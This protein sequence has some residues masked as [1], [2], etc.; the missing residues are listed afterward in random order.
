VIADLSVNHVERVVLLEG[1][2][3]QRIIPDYGYD[4]SITTCDVDGYV[5]NGLIFLQLKASESLPS[6]GSDFVFDA[7]VR[8]Y[9]LW[10]NERFPVMLILDDAG[11][12]RAYWLHIQGYFL[13]PDRRPKR[14]AK[15]IRIRVPQSQ[16]F[17]RRSVA[18]MRELCQRR[19][20]R[21]AEETPDG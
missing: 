5:E 1:H 19:A 6:V 9:I 18:Q 10:T 8:D 3:V 2:T 11:R 13:D 17:N 15:T 4:L 16:R 20:I 21:I 12:E 7:S 14:G